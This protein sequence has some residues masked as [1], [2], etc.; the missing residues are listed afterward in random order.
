MKTPLEDAT[1]FLALSA[2]EV[3]QMRNVFH[4]MDTNKSGD[5]SV[6]EF[7]VFIKEKRTK[8][9]DR[10]FVIGSPDE[11]AEEEEVVQ[12]TFGEFLKAIGQFCMFGPPEVGF[13]SVRHFC[14]CCNSL[15]YIFVLL[16]FASFVCFCV[17]TT[18][19]P[20]FQCMTQTVWDTFKWQRWRS[21]SR[22]FMDQGLTC[23]P[24]K[25]SPSLRQ[26][27]VTFDEVDSC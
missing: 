3:G 26:M 11:E 8:V 2:R 4:K 17:C 14:L 19:I 23:L 27:T 15:V 6:D 20:C 22:W 10:I 5:I 24:I 1:E 7:S 9:I 12:L 18:D 21:C 25:H 13:L 16:C